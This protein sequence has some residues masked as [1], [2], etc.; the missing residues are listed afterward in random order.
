[1]SLMFFTAVV[2]VF[3]PAKVG[4]RLFNHFG[5]IRLVTTLT[6]WKIPIALIAIRKGKVKTHK[7]KMILLYAGAILIADAFTLI[8]GRYLREVFF[9]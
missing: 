1:M 6:L 9:G 7:R 8:P 3:Q 2:T 5:W 4:T